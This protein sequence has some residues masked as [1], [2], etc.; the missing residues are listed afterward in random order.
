M[1][2]NEVLQ[3]KTLKPLWFPTM[4]VLTWCAFVLATTLWIRAGG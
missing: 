3:M 4:L 1:K 2:L